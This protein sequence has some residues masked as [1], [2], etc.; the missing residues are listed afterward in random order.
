MAGLGFDAAIMADVQD[1]MKDRLG[2]L[3][4]VAA[5]AR[6]LR[7]PQ[8]RVQLTYD[9]EEPD[10]PPGPDRAGR[11]RR[12]DRRRDHADAGRPDRRRLPGHPDPVAA[13][14]RRLDGGGGPGAD[15]AAYRAR[16]V[17]HRRCRRLR[18]TVDEPQPVQ[19]D[20]DVVAEVRS[21]EIRLDRLALIVRMPEPTEPRPPEPRP[22]SSEAS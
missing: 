13:R 7:G 22:S 2:W 10:H 5:G 16:R 11:Q 3:A 6:N 4:Y 18:I 12:A 1:G 21:V 19:V 14:G 20:G 8:M 17:E 9:D 15:P